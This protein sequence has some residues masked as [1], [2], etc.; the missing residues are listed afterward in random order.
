[1]VTAVD[2]PAVEVTGTVVVGVAVVG[3]A[4]VVLATA[5]VDASAVD[6]LTTDSVVAAVSSVPRAWT[7]STAT[8]PKVAAVATAAATRRERA[9][10]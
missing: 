6:E 5:A 2:R 10:G 7:P 8:S 9:A 4:V 1:M 3:V